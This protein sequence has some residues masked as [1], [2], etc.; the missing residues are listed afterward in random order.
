GTGAPGRVG[1][2]APAAIVGEATPL[3]IPGSPEFVLPVSSTRWLMCDGRRIALCEPTAERWSANLLGPDQ[4]AIDGAVLFG[5]RSAA[6][7]VEARDGEASGGHQIVIVGVHGPGV[8]HRLAL[9]GV[10]AVPVAPV[11]P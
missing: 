7:V 6:I 2:A 4:R 3:P 8:Q 5:G 1:A 11:R 10:D 9:V